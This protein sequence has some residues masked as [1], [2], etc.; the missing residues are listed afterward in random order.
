[1]TSE[2]II[3]NCPPTELSHARAVAHRAVQLV[4]AAARANLEPAAD[5]SHSNLGWDKTSRL[6]VSQPLPGQDGDR[7]VGLTL[8]PLRL[9]VIENDQSQASCNLQGLALSDAF[10]WLD[11]QLMDRG[12]SPASG[13]RIPY[14]LPTEVEAVSGFQTE[15]VADQMECLAGWFDLAAVHLEQFAAVHTDLSPGPGPVRCWPHHFDIATYVQLETGDFESARGVGVG[16]SPGDESYNQP[17]FYINPWPHLDPS[18]LPDLPPPGHWQT[19][20]FVGAIATGE[21]VLTLDDIARDLPQ[22]IGRAFDI[23][24]TRLGL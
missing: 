17:Y 13:A 6:F 5:D 15:D 20:G 4:T 14:G 7:F 24:Q 18:D 21:E 23:G 2:S 3:R 22:F 12:L 19:E 11:G 9:N 10:R 16:L 8:A 1:M